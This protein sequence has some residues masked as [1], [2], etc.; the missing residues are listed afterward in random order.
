MKQC[1]IVLAAIIL[2]SSVLSAQTFQSF[3]NRVT[4]APDSE[5]TAIVDSFMAAHPQ[6]PYIENDT[7]VHFIYR[8]TTTDVTV[9]GDA[10]GWS[11]SSFPMT[12][13]STTTLW[14]VTKKFES[15]ARLDYKFVTNGN[16]WILDP[17]N[18]Y[19][20]SGGFGPNSELRMPDYVPAQE[21]QYNSS[22]PH[23]TFKDSTFHSTALNNNRTVRVYL[24]PTYSS[25]TDSFPMV[26]VHDGLE[27]ISLAKMNNVLDYLIANNRIQPLIA[28]FVPPVNRTPEYAGSQIRQFSSFIVDELMPFIDS[29]YR[30][31]KDPR[32]RATLGASN[33]GNI[34]LYLATFYPEVFGNVAAQSSNIIDTISSK[35]ENSEPLDVKVYLDLGTY[36]ISVLIPLVR[37]FIPLL[38]TKGYVY[39]Y[40][41]YHE[42]HSWG[43][44]RAHIDDALE[45]FFPG[46]ALAVGD[47]PENPSSIELYQNYPNPFNPSTVIRYSLSVNSRVTLK[48]YDVLGREVATLVDGM[49][50]AGEKTVE[51]SAGGGASGLPSGVYYY[52]LIAV[53]QDGILSYNIQ[54]TMLL[55]K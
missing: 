19:Q 28:V 53:G 29:R 23:G 21:I 17:K 44:W 5:R 9:P 25:T 38:Q 49:Q 55:L 7:T 22:I 13:L 33:G 8:G 3:I 14:H 39:R 6:L 15:D 31:M 26:L 52:R 4:S 30:T 18:P 50:E 46:H 35:I 51:W 32:Y 2:F 20:V 10:N 27:Y 48:V 37:N 45:F 43:N 16:N 54:K 24:P 42:G 40:A 1:T 41:E 12:K 34:A 11:Q 47:K 36:D